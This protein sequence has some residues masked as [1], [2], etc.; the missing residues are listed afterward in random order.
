M[1][2]ICPIVLNSAVHKNRVAIIDYL[3]SRGIE[4]DTTTYWGMEYYRAIREADV[5]INV[6]GDSIKEA[7]NKRLFE[8]TGMGTC[9][10]TDNLLGLDKLFKKHTEVAVFNNKYDCYLAIK[11][12]EKHPKIRESIAK[13]GQRRTIQGH[14][15][16]R[17]LGQW[18]EIFSRYDYKKK[19]PK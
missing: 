5:V 3:V 15:T 14:T 9:L 6:H 7:C 10:L 12:L 8:V 1:K 19:K 4:I 16:K 13:A 2:V 17:R 18:N 11:Y